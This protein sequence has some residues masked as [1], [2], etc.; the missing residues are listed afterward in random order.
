[1]SFDNLYGEL[2]NRLVLQ[3][4]QSM[5]LAQLLP[6]D[7]PLVQLVIQEQNEL[8]RKLQEME[9]SGVNM[10]D[11]GWPALVI[12]AHVMQQNKRCLL[13]YHA[14]RLGLISTAYWDAGGA[15]AHVLNCLQE[16]MSLPEI[17]YLRDYGDSVVTYRDDISADDAVDLALGITRPPK[18]LMVTVEAIIAPGPIQTQSGTID[19]KYGQRY[20]LLKSDVEHLILQGYLKEVV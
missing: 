10:G 11:E 16:N 15:A 12:L 9:R 19:F 20:I 7:G 2:A 5:N 8:D 14:Q 13:A 6:Y 4:K 18:E 3:S 17:R 1:M